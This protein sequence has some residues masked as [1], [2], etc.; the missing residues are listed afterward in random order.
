MKSN[1]TTPIDFMHNQQNAYGMYSPGHNIMFISL[2]INKSGFYDCEDRLST[3]YHEYAHYI[4]YKKMTGAERAEWRDI[5]NQF[6]ISERYTLDSYNESEY[7]KETWAFSFAIYLTYKKF[8]FSDEFDRL[9]SFE[10]KIFMK[11]IE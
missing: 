7:V 8:Y 9:D 6:N 3:V 4:W 2:G 5:Y 11:Y 10:R 1:I